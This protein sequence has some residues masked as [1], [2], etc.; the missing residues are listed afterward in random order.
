LSLRAREIHL[1]PGEI[2]RTRRVMSMARADLWRSQFM[3]QSIHG[4]SLF[5]TRSVNSLNERAG[6]GRQTARQAYSR[7]SDIPRD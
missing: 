2:R 3:T 7:C 4:V 5:M 6:Q 1:P